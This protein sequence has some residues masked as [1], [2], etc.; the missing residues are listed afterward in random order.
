MASLHDYQPCEYT[1]RYDPKSNVW[2]PKQYA[3]YDIFKKEYLA[4]AYTTT[5]LFDQLKMLVRYQKYKINNENERADYIK[6][7][8]ILNKEA[9]RRIAPIE[10]L[11]NV[12]YT[13][14]VTMMDIIENKESDN[15]YF[16]SLENFK[17]HMISICEV[18]RNNLNNG[19][20]DDDRMKNIPDLIMKLDNIIDIYRRDEVSDV[21]DIVKTMEM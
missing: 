11:Q 9:L 10:V 13:E 14:S 3:S 7:K 15:I 20:Y 18:L 16:L 17:I 12:K 19:I 1:H 4:K 5:V 21:T 2:Y 6:L 8:I